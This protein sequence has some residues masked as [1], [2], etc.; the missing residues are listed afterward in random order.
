MSSALFYT[1]ANSILALTFGFKAQIPPKI[2][3]FGNFAA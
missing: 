1:R 2:G 3:F